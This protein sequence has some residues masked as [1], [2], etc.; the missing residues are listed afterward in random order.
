MILLGKAVGLSGEKRCFKK[1]KHIANS[2]PE[3]N[4]I[5]AADN[6]PRESDPL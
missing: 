4:K 5:L 2:C 3:A 6:E 1:A